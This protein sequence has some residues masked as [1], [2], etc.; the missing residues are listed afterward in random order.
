MDL[1]SDYPKLESPYIRKLYQVDVKSWKS[2]GKSLMRGPEL[3]LATNE[4]DQKYS[5]VFDDPDTVAVEKLDGTN[6]KVRSSENAIVQVQNR[7][8]PV[9][10]S[11]VPINVKG[12][13]RGIIGAV[14]NSACQPKEK[15]FILPNTT[16][17]GEAIGPNIQSNPYEL[18][19]NLWYPFRKS[20]ISLRYNNFNKQ[21]MTFT[22]L[23]GWMQHAIRSRFYQKYHKS[24]WEEA[25]FAE[26]VVFVN[27]RRREEGKS[28]QCKLRRD[29]YAWYYPE[30]IKILGLE[31]YHTRAAV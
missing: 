19:H 4:V 28:W 3:Y 30:T 18:S 17:A 22:N 24:A 2:H 15:E 5:W 20:L 14:V 16:E 21:E 11:P 13:H 27:K 25:P 12:H 6:V 10:I 7:Q 1:L 31:D 8:N 29:M 9:I 26:G 23:S